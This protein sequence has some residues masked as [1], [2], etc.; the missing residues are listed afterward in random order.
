MRHRPV[1]VPLLVNIF[2]IPCSQ[3]L[4]NLQVG[5]LDLPLALL[6]TPTVMSPYISV[7][8]ITADG[9]GASS[10]KA[11]NTL[12]RSRLQSGS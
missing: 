8:S 3:T 6:L 12:L 2:C 1:R 5:K 10:M 4:C 11:R 7:W 9:T